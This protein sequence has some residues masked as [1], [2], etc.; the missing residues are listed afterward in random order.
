MDYGQELYWAGLKD[1]L[2]DVKFSGPILKRAFE[3]PFKRFQDRFKQCV[4]Y[5]FSSEVLKCDIFLNSPLNNFFRTS[6]WNF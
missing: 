3:G 2:H 1:I 6:S 5:W 4:V